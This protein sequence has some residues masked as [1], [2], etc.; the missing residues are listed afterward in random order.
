MIPWK[1]G[2]KSF[3]PF[4]SYYKATTCRAR[5]SK[6]IF[7]A[8][9]WQESSPTPGDHFKKNLVKKYWKFIFEKIFW[10]KIPGK[11]FKSFSKKMLLEKCSKK[12]FLKIKKK[13][14]GKC[15]KKSKF[16]KNFPK[17]TIF[18]ATFFENFWVLF[19]KFF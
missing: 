16:L 14:I 18:F 17:K 9:N 11:I 19:G 13:R 1:M 8:E 12:I 2:R 5:A 15:V 3:F 4:L 7:F 6:L 10:K